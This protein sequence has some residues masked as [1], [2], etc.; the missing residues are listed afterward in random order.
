MSFYV[1]SCMN[2]NDVLR[3][4]KAGDFRMVN[5][6]FFGT[7][8]PPSL[9]MDLVSILLLPWLRTPSK[10][11]K[12]IGIR[13]ICIKK[14]KHLSWSHLRDF[15]NQWHE[16][17]SD[18]PRFYLRNQARFCAANRNACTFFRKVN[19]H[20]KKKNDGFGILKSIDAQSASDA[21]PTVFRYGCN[22]NSC[23]KEKR[24]TCSKQW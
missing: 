19:D 6:R 14:S 17:F 21:T 2:V 24:D 9:A 8:P 10:C 22:F 4:A 3:A 12:R 23:R 16:F 1:L 7:G 13:G 20:P 15:V 18:N 11:I 5:R